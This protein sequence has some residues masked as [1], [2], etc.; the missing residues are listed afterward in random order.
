MDDHRMA[1]GLSRHPHMHSHAALGWCW[2]MTGIQIGVPTPPCGSAGT[3]QWCPGNHT[4]VL[5]V[6]R[7]KNG[8]A[9]ATFWQHWNK[10]G[11]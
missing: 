8:N 6:G 9:Q 2:H 5:R 1:L 10:A 11:V 4:V 3:W 7:L